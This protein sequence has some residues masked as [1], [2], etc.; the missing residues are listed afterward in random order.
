MSRPVPTQVLHFTR[1]EHLPAI[2]AH[3][4]LSDAR[5]RDQGLISVEIGNTRIKSSRSMTAVPVHPRGV[6]ADYVPFYFAPRSPMMYSI[7]HGRVPTYQDG[8]GRLV[9]L[10]TTLEWL[11]ASGLEIVLTDRNAVLRVAD[12]WNLADGEPVDDF[13]DWPLMTERYWYSTDEYPDRMERRMAECLVHNRVP[14]DAFEVVVA[15]DQHT[16][17]EATTLLSRARAAVHV[18]VRPHWYF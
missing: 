17:N 4:L 6:V 5:A 10:V 13:I 16:A 3:G 9:Y 7:H 14:F 11:Q 1:V 2:V 8:C 12:F 15:R 18:T